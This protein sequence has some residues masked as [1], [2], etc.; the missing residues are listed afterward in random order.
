MSSVTSVT[1]VLILQVRDCEAERGQV[2]DP[3]FQR[4]GKSAADSSPK[5]GD[6]FTDTPPSPHLHKGASFV[7]ESKFGFRCEVYSDLP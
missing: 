5:P 1:D 3:R 2:S 6:T 7:G 4:W